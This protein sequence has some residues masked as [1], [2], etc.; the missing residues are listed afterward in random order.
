MK[1]Q[2]NTTLTAISGLQV[3]H[4]QHQDRPTGCTVVLC[5]QGAVAGIDV[6]GAAPGTRETD[7]LQPGHTVP[8][9]HAIVMSGGSAYGLDAA[10]GVMRWLE[11]HGHGLS[12]GPAR[13]PIVPAAVIFDL[14][15]GD[16][17]VRPDAHT[18]WAACENASAQP[19]ACGNVGAGAGATV[20]KVF[21]PELAMKG[22]LGSALITVG[23]WQVGALVVCNALGDVVDPHTG[24]IVAGS[25]SSPQALT[26]LNTTQA[27]LR[28]D[29]PQSLIAGTHTT[30]GVVAC[31]AALDKAQAQRLAVAGHDGLARTIRPVH[32]PMDGDTLFGLATARCAQTPD[33]MLLGTMAAE[34]VAQATLHAVR[35]ASGLRWG[36]RWWP[37][38]D[39]LNKR[40]V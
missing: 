34:A 29:H 31:N 21:G 30:I 6:R 8:H 36:D 25:R 3:G 40:P 11:H 22:G 15:V 20:G 2:L 26:A 37:A 18:G 16:A 4:A 14:G 10:S 1:T 5:P 12:V 32:T 19:V 23:P 13:V 38:A 17:S 9:V 33:L 28:G 35:S 39:D 7:A 24:A 27:L